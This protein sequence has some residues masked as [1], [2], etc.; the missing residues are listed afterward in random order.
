M[1]SPEAALAPRPYAELTV[2]AH[3]V[4][5]LRDG[6]EA[7]PAML[8]AID[9]AQ[10]TV[11]IETYILREDRAGTRFADALR[12][13]AEAGVEV[14]LMYDDWG[15]SVSDEFLLK[16]RL[17]GVRTLAF[18][19]V[20]FSGRLARLIA[21]L[22]RRNHRKT[23]VVDGEVAFTG[24]LNLSDDYAAPAD[25]GRGWR[26]THVRLQGPAAVEL[27]Q[28]FLE[29]W[30]RHGGKPVTERLYRRAPAVGDDKVHVVH[31]EFRLDRKGV[32]KAYLNAFTRA[33]QRIDITQAYFLPPLKLL[34]TL[35]RAS[36]RGV[37]VRVILPA[38]TDVTLVFLAARGLYGKLL[39]AGVRVFEWSGRVLHAKTAVVDGHWCT[40]GSANLDAL[41]LRQNLEVNAV[42]ED[43]AMGAV[44]EKMFDEDLAH[45]EEITLDAWRERPLLEQ[46]MSWVAYQL[47]AWL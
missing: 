25:G 29:T 14:N 5:L 2:G 17:S 44:F 26:D 40:V 41:S 30:R 39:R 45:C 35:L 4:A 27:E 12:A 18:Q 28:I 31:N 10:Q 36:R 22:R 16:L 43:A 3:Q 38:T 32:R 21:R 1:A 13:R 15:S 11:C 7:Y 9:A 37:Q 46:L 6:G 33:R 19:P 23:L 8:A 20:A 47:R 42:F 24:G 34:R